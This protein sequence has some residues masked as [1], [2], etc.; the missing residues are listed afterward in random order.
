MSP[1]WSPDGTKIVFAAG[2]R[3]F[4][5]NADGSNLQ[6]ICDSGSYP[7]WSPDGT[8]IAFDSKRDGNSDIYVMNAD[9]SNAVRLTSDPGFDWNPCWSP[10]GRKIAFTSNRDGNNEIY[11]MN[12]DGTDQVN[13]TNNP[14]DDRDPEW[15][16]QAYQLTE[17]TQ[18]EGGP[19][20]SFPLEGFLPWGLAIL[21]ASL[22]V[23][24]IIFVRQRVILKRNET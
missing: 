12:S 23:I 11:L 20:I 7:S 17:S 14:V 3:I 10:D 15:C 4:V 18:P 9:G 21:V 8:K 5:M 13:I 6:K 19:H 2:Q 24:L 1:E 16:C 22:M